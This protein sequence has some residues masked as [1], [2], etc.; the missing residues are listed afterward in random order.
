MN[1]TLTQIRSAMIENLFGYGILPANFLRWKSLPHLRSSDSR[2]NTFVEGICL[3]SD[4]FSVEKTDVLYRSNCGLFPVLAERNGRASTI[5]S[6]LIQRMHASLVVVLNN[7]QGM[8]ERTGIIL[9][10]DFEEVLVPQALWNKYKQV[11]QPV[12]SCR[13]VIVHNYIVRD[14]EGIN[15]SAAC[16]RVPDYETRLLKLVQ[17]EGRK[18]WIHGIRLPIKDDL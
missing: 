13:L 11:F 15:F 2:V 4:V 6:I 14:V 3:S 12:G 7:S 10:S 1:E 5:R 18:I 9:P 17:D 8:I 16:L